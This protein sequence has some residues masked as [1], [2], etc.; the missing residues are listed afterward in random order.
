MKQTFKKKTNNTAPTS[1]ETKAHSAIKTSDAQLL[2]T[3]KCPRNKNGSASLNRGREAVTLMDTVFN[4]K[5]GTW[6]KFA[7]RS[8]P[9]AELLIQ[10]E[11]FKEQGSVYP[12]EEN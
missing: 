9:D 7:S 2:L 4:F 8:V 6:E 1:K 3:V 5:K 10:N 11:L 12:S